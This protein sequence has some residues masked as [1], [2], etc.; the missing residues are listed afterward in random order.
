VVNQ[1][2]QVEQEAAKPDAPPAVKGKEWR[3]LRFAD[4]GLPTY[5]DVIFASG[6]TL[7]K[8]PDLVRRYLKA[9]QRGMDYVISHP[10][11]A[12]ETLAAFPGQ[13]E[14][15]NKLKWRFKLQN[16][17]FQSADTKTHGYLWMNPPTWEQMIA[18][19]VEGEQIPKPIPVAEVM[20]DDYL[21]KPGSN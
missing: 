10:D 12:A 7:K 4:F 18:V 6:D 11:E 20:T 13:I 8:N 14:D 5:S 16:Q 15:I 2:Y 21:P 17:L 3:A 9:V 1:T 19:L